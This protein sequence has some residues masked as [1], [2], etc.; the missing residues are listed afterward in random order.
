MNEARFTMI[1]VKDA[2]QRA[3]QQAGAVLG[4]N[5]YRLEEIERERYNDRDVWGITLSF[6]RDLEKIPAPMRF[7]ADPLEYKRFLIDVET[8]EFQAMRIREFASR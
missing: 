1:D 5:I 8:G 4:E 6:P 7:A 2:V 3:K